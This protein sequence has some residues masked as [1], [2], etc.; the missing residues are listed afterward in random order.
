MESIR[1]SANRQLLQARSAGW[2]TGRRRGIWRRVGGF[3]AFATATLL[4]SATAP[5]SAGPRAVL[6]SNDSQRCLD[7]AKGSQEPRAPA[8]LFD[9]HG[10]ANQ[11]WEFTSAGELRTFGGARCLDIRGASVEPQALVQSYPCHGGA[12]QKW[13]MRADKTIVNPK[14]GLCLTVKGG[15]TANATGI[16][17][18]HCQG[19]PHQ[20]W[21][22]GGSTPPPTDTQA[23]TPPSGLAIADLTCRSARLTWEPSTDDVGIAYYDIYRDG[24]ALGTVNAST[25][26]AQLVLVP[27]ANWGV[28]VNARDAAGNVSQ[29]SA[30][31]PVKVPQCQAD[32]QPPSAPTGLQGTVAGTAVTL[33]WTTSTDNVAVVAYDVY[34]NNILVGT[35]TTRGY[36]DTGL[37]ANTTYQYTVAARD[38]QGNVSA[39]SAAL[40]LTSGSTC[41]DVICS[42]VEVARDT[43]IPWGLAALPDGTVFYSRRDAHEV[44]A[45]NPVTGSKRSLGT[46]PNVQ[47]TD[48]E[49][50]LLGLAIPPGFPDQDSWLY[51]YHTSPTDNRIVRIRYRNG[52][53]DASS[54]EVLLKGISRNKFHN[55]G[56]LRFGPDGKLYAATGDAQNGAYAQDVRHLSG[57]ILRLNANG[58]PPPD[59]PFGNYV[60]SYGHRN[61]QGLAFDSQGRL[62][63]QEFGDTQ[64]ETNL[65]Q[66]GG[67]YGW[68]N[69]EGILS[70]SGTGCATTGYLAPK[71]TY[72]NTEASCSGMAIVRDALYVACLAGKRVYRFDIRGDNLSNARQFFNGT[73]DRLRTLEPTIDGNMWLTSS[74]AAGDKDSI[75]NNTDTA[76]YKIILNRN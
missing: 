52:A 75:P 25:L 48:G 54:L 59:N 28:Y 13:T 29:A 73:Y 21:S 60:W 49:G 45:L 71:Y 3:V 67:N 34:R 9:C 15:E 69:C 63:A 31:L 39:R 18:W 65:I 44:V 42:T 19:T 6:V 17:T 41:T 61:P 47:G 10:G 74:D 37:A 53:L 58:T 64:D 20:Q 4:L 57:K 8:I 7:I 23:P 51:V 1:K 27:G 56:R 30:S 14:S 22:I 68:P 35:S 33:S 55:G 40:S 12:N 2:E 46:V 16:D 43:D 50:G 66:K 24:Q 11:L 62:W 26:T 72:R 76:M 32:T 70:R 5:V 36:T 38:G